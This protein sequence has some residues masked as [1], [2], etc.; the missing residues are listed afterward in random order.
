MLMPSLMPRNSPGR[1][2]GVPEGEVAEGIAAVAEAVGTVAGAA[3]LMACM[4]DARLRA[5]TRLASLPARLYDFILLSVSAGS[6]P[7]F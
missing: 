1:A 7:Y 5:R 4:A 2:A 3:W 6:H